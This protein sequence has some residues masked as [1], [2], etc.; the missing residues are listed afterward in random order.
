MPQHKSKLCSSFRFYQISQISQISASITIRSRN[1]ISSSTIYLLYGRVR[2]FQ[3]L[4]E[5]YALLGGKSW[6]LLDFSRLNPIALNK[7]EGSRMKRTGT[8]IRRMIIVIAHGAVHLL[9][10]RYSEINSFH[11][12][13]LTRILALSRRTR[14]HVT[15]MEIL[16][17]RKTLTF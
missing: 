15:R 3:A 14:I 10:P 16:F 1:F 17:P 9:A 11:R 8:T 6:R 7:K 4:R 13:K 12:G 2:P 5:Q